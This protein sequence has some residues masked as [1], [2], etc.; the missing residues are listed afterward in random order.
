MHAAERVALSGV[1]NVSRFIGEADVE[2]IY[3]WVN[4]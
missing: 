1:I 2:S 3:L 4:A